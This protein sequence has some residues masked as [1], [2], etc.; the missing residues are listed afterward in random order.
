M[1]FELG[2]NTSRLAWTEA[3]KG[4]PLPRAETTKRNLL[5]VL[6]F[7]APGCQ[8]C[9]KSIPVLNELLRK[10]KDKIALLGVGFGPGVELQSDELVKLMEFPVLADS[11]QK[12]FNS[13][14][15][16]S[17]RIPCVAVLAADGR[18]LWRGNPDQLEKWLEDHLAGKYDL[19]AAIRYDRMALA[20]S[21][22]MRKKD[23]A[24]AEKALDTE[25]ALVPNNLILVVQ[26]AKLQ[27]E[28][29][30]DI[31]AAIQTLDA[32]LRRMPNTYV[33]HEL[34]LQLLRRKGDAVASDAASIALA[35][36]F[37][38]DPVM[39]LG[40]LRT[41]LRRPGGEFNFTLIRELLGKLVPQT[42]KL[43][44]EQRLVYY[45]SAAKYAYLTGALEIAVLLQKKATPGA[46]APE[47]ERLRHLAELAYYQSALA[48]SRKN[49]WLSSIK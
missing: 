7:W 46:K 49:E 2:E 48:A 6:Y 33:L 25:L 12:I 44:D 30:Q 34:K 13:F 29:R 27:A 32:A 45:E 37:A 35:Q 23:Y 40:L 14:M 39:L 36:A 42:T 4:E 43:T 10:R 31:T 26:K 21:E 28:E 9:K 47:K 5:T 3:I 19:A 8:P 18:F 38:N 20:F 15:R 41:E 24:A 16:R 1:G 11:T 22:A 17:D